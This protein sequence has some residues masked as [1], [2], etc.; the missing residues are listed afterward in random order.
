[1]Q[2]NISFSVENSKGIS[3]FNLISISNSS[4]IDSLYKEKKCSESRERERESEQFAKVNM[5]KGI[6][7]TYYQA[8]VENRKEIIGTLHNETGQEAKVSFSTAEINVSNRLKGNQ[9]THIERITDK[10]M[11]GIFASS[12]SE[13]ISSK[14]QTKTKSLFD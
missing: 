14:T 8:E 10:E 11:A 13:G 6:E 4:Q 9:N 12:T 1:M 3:N 7:E 5:D 2:E